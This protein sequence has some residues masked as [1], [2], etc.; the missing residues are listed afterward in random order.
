MEYIEGTNI[1]KEQYLQLDCREYYRALK[2][3]DPKMFSVVDRLR[4]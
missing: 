2:L 4:G 1:F 3:G